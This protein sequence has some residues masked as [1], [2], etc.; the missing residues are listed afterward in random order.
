MAGGAEAALSAGDAEIEALGLPLDR[1][2]EVLDLG[3]GFGMHAIPLARR[4]AQVTAID[5]SAELLRTL[6]GLGAG[7]PLRAVNGDLLDFPRHLSGAPA[8]ILCMGDTITHLPDSGSVKKLV[9]RAFAE[10]APGGA[11]V[12]TF[13]DYSV[14]LEGDRRFI[15]VRSDESRVLTCFIEYE[16]QAVIVHDIVHERAAQGWQTR[17]SHYRKLRLSPERLAD[18]L[19][20]IGFEVRSEA[21]ARGMVRLVARKAA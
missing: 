1:G 17:V 21:G 18:R 11:L 19:R 12:V 9:E 13:R 2:A 16:P 3:A 7:L 6:A 4:G 5:S 10:L 14:A 15:P 20:R 8:A